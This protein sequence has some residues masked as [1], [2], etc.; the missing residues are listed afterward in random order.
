MTLNKALETA[1]TGDWDSAWAEAKKDEGL[2]PGV[3]FSQW[4]AFA[5]KALERRNDELSAR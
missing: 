4:K 3:T 2:L 5:I 1:S